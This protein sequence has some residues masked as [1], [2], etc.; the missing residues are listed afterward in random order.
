MPSKATGMSSFFSRYNY[1]VGSRSQL[2]VTLEGQLLIVQEQ[3]FL[4]PV[5]LRFDNS[6][7]DNF[8]LIIH[9]NRDDYLSEHDYMYPSRYE[10]FK[11]WR[12]D[13]LPILAV[14]RKKRFSTAFTVMRPRS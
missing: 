12:R 7:V 10:I 1:C 9:R 3:K 4:P 6:W 13:S 2:E 8:L 5:I 11:P 14:S